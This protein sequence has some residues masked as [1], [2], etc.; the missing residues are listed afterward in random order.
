L[1]DPCVESLQ[2]LQN[3]GRT[4]G[5]EALE[6]RENVVEETGRGVCIGARSKADQSKDMSTRGRAQFDITAHRR[7][8]IS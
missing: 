7:D 8:S 2:S 1:G 4:R 3:R 5:G 6:S